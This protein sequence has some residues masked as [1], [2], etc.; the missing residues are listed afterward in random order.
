MDSVICVLQRG[1]EVR[2]CLSFS[3][4]LLAM[5][6]RIPYQRSLEIESRMDRV[7]RLIASGRYST[8]LL[9]AELAVSVPTVSRYVKALRQRGYDIR[10]ERENDGWR[11]TLVGSRPEARELGTSLRGN[12]FSPVRERRTA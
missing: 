12:W 3:D 5:D 6:D 8:P 4:R 11:Y 2:S 1:Q 9:A 10:P 7:L